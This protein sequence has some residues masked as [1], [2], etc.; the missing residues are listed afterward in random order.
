MDNLESLVLGVASKRGVTLRFVNVMQDNL[1][2]SSS[3][4]PGGKRRFQVRFMGTVTHRSGLLKMKL[5]KKKRMMMVKK[6]DCF[7]QGLRTKK[8]A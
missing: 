5:L 2:A 3:S 8:F 6:N 7:D 1:S 4:Y